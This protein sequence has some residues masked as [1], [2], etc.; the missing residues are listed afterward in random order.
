LRKGNPWRRAT[1]HT[2]S[3]LVAISPTIRALSSS[4]HVRRRPAPLNTSSRRTGS[5][6]PICSVSILSPTV[7]TKPQT[8]RSRHHPEGGG[9]TALTAVP[10]SWPQIGDDFESQSA[11]SIMTAHAPW[12]HWYKQSL[13]L[14]NW[15]VG[16]FV[17]ISGNTIK[18]EGIELLS[19]LIIRSSTRDP[20]A[21]HSSAC[22]KMQNENWRR[23][24]STDRSRLL[25]LADQSAASLA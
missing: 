11:R 21:R 9:R 22:T 4:R 20:K 24:I 6:I 2:E 14:E 17:E 19:Q 13:Q 18:L 10:N 3:P 8:R 5:M 15:L 25:R 7:Q 12:L 23:A 16:K 1:A